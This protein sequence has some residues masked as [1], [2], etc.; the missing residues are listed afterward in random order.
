M[1]HPRTTA[2]TLNMHADTTTETTDTTGNTLPYD[3]TTEH[4]WKITLS[5]AADS[6][7]NH[8]RK[9]RHTASQAQT[10]KR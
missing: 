3:G 8:R 9:A 1:P 5:A 4:R 7:R 2:L 10:T 6:P